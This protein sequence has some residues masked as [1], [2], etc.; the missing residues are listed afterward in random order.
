M[1]TLLFAY[2]S[3]AQTYPSTAV[4]NRRMKFLHN[5]QVYLAS[6]SLAFVW[7]AVQLVMAETTGV[8]LLHSTKSDRQCIVEGGVLEHKLCCVAS[9]P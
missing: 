3:L 4:S 7:S 5:T 8:L 2:A 1:V 9:Q 6:V